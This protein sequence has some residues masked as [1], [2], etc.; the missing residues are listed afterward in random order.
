[1]APYQVVEP[2]YNCKLPGVIE[3]LNLGGA[4]QAAKSPSDEQNI[5]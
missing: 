4:L 1:M 5:K 3:E 2:M